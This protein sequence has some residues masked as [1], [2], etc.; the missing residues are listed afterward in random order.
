M[1][2]TVALLGSQEVRVRVLWPA[3]LALAEGPCRPSC[4]VLADGGGGGLRCGHAS[5]PLVWGQVWFEV[6]ACVPSFILLQHRFLSMLSYSL[7]HLLA[8][9]LPL[10]YFNV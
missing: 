9:G 5:L 3:M 7:L 2:R 4:S 6:W 1:R 10:L 8:A